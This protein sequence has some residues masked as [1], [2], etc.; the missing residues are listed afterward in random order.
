LGRIAVKHHSAAGTVALYG[1][2]VTVSSL[3]HYMP[4]VNRKGQNTDER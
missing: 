2:A 1:R 3:T 4:C